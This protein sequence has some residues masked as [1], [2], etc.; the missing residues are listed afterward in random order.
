[1]KFCNVSGEFV[2]DMELRV[3]GSSDE[4]SITVKGTHMTTVFEN[5][6]VNGSAPLVITEGDG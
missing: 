3:L 1:M 4:Y 6:G 2:V 5:V